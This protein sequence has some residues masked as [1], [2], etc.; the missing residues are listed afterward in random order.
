[1]VHF[2]ITVP[3]SHTH[4][5]ASQLT[6]PWSTSPWRRWGRSWWT[7]RLTCWPAIGRT[8]LARPLSARLELVFCWSS[9]WARPVCSL[10]LVCAFVS[11]FFCAPLKMKLLREVIMWMLQS[12]IIFFHLLCVLPN[13]FPVLCSLI[14]LPLVPFGILQL[15]REVW[16]DM[17]YLVFCFLF[18]PC[19]VHRWLAALKSHEA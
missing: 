2:G 4:I 13:T 14:S 16:C 5:S 7:R 17:M 9:G 8:V 1:M 18:S 15:C 11:F 19:V 10:C 6:V 3:Y 12:Y